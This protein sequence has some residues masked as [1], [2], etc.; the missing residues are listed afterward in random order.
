M[1]VADEIRRIKN[2]LKYIK[3]QLR[4]V[5]Q[6]GGGI[7]AHN[8]LDGDVHLD[9]VAD[10]V[11]R[12]SI[13]YG[14]ATPKWARL[15]K[16][17]DDKILTMKSGLPSWEAAAGGGGEVTEVGVK[18]LSSDFDNLALGDVDGKGSHDYAGTW[19]NNSG[20]NCLAN[21]IEDPAGGHM[22]SLID[23]SG[24][25][26]SQVYIDFNPGCEVI[27]GIVEVKAKISVQA[28]GS[29]GYFTIEDKG[30]SSKHGGYF[31][32]NFSRIEYLTATGSTG[33]LVDAPVDTWFTVKWYFSRLA[34]YGVWWVD[35]VFTQ[36]RLFCNAGNKYH[37]INFETT[38]S[39]NGITL[40]IKYVKV[41]NL[42]YV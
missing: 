8:I 37:R 26:K 33:K 30:V 21:I 27:T 17:D 16:G 31:S 42:N 20:A 13:I 15:A 41:W 40:D 10:G 38:T 18:L 39:R 22:L 36:P 28:E 19:V 12:G 4:D 24:T 6:G 1:N 14:N 32:G 34:S 23:A 35:G 29:K 11:T 7:A 9:S 3:L 5:R 25:Y 2:E